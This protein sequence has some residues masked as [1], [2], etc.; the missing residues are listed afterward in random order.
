M[1]VICVQLGLTP[2]RRELTV[3]AEG[4]RQLNPAFP[5]QV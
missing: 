5:R 4:G 1:D 2:N 3:K